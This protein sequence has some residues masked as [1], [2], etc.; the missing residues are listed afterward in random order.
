MEIETIAAFAA[1]GVAA[2]AVPATLL[3]GRWQLRTGLR[4][5]EATAR[6]GIAQ[7]EATY[8]AALDGV[9]A[10][11][12]A[13]Q[14]QWRRG[15][16]RESYAAF[17]LATHQVV[18]VSDRLARDV[19]AQV[20]DEASAAVLAA[21]VR[22][23]EA[24]L[25]AAMLVVTLEGPDTVAEAAE[26]ITNSAFILAGGCERAVARQL[27]TRKLD[28]M[29]ETSGGGTDAVRCGHAQQLRNALAQLGSTIYPVPDYM[30]PAARTPAVSAAI[31]V[32]D[33]ALARLPTGTFT[34]FERIELLATELSRDPMSTE[35]YALAS[36]DLEEQKMMFVR[37]A[38][39]ELDSAGPAA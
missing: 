19:H 3:V 18:E 20:V 27:V 36:D 12:S 13:T 22:Q 35:L 1:A 26:M 30:N 2:V 5:A 9:K 17:L 8:R 16:Q 15:V 32:V 29:T 37:A 38:R 4:A 24:S 28:R 7:A 33:A 31:E 39:A 11:A 10:Q 34:A 14:I 21:E 6:A 23:A 25:R